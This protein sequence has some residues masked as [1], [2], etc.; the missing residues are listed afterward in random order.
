MI[1]SCFTLLEAFFNDDKIIGLIVH[2]HT[3][4][5]ET[6]LAFKKYVKEREEK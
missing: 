1:L 6:I 2:F 3:E 5:K 4:L